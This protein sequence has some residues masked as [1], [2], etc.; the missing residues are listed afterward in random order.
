M[1]KTGRADIIKNAVPVGTQ[2][3]TYLTAMEAM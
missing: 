3:R 2:H 1:Y